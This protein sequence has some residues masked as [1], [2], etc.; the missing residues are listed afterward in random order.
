[1]RLFAIGDIHGCSEALRHLDK[2]LAFNASDTV[3]TLGDYVDRGP[4]SRGV[5]EFLLEL[6]GRCRLVS[7]RG[8][9]EI[10]MLKARD[11]RANL[12]E[13][14]NY[15]GDTT[16]D[17]YGA[18]TFADI[19]DA[20]WDFLHSTI[21]YHET[22]TDFFVHANACPD[23]SLADQPDYMLFWE[24]VGEPS[25]HVSG[26]RM[27]CGHS[28]QRSGSPLDFGHAVCIDTFAHGGGWLTCLEMRSNAYWQTSQNGAL[29]YDALQ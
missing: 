10:M 3:V 17:S 9:H 6:R 28:A 13:W 25:P 18:S 12:S 15:R 22:A 2:E 7:L 5:I 8:N 27:I 11:Q 16:L 20:H 14:L 4:D 26:R 29:R 24:F 21:P 23:I 1:M 19:P